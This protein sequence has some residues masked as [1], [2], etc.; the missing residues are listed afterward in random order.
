MKLLRLLSTM[1][2]ERYGFA[3]R[4]APF[5]WRRPFASFPLSGLSGDIDLSA[6]IYRAA[7]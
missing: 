6:R 1:P 4:R 5:L 7:V 2:P 3:A